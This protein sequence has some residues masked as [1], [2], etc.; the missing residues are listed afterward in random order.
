[1][2]E[3]VFS[4]EKIK[5]MILPWFLLI[6]GL[7]TMAYG[8]IFEV[9]LFPVYSYGVLEDYRLWEI[10]YVFI[11]NYA[12]RAWPTLLFAFM[13]GGF[14]I[15][16]IPRNKMQYYLSSGKYLPYF[17]AALLAPLM[18]VCSCAM[19]P[20]FGGLV[21]SGAGIG[22]AITFLLMAPAANVMALIT[23][24]DLI[25]LDMALARLVF[26]FI[27]AVIIGM[28]IGRTRTGKAVEKMFAGIKA[29]NVENTN[30]ISF[31]EKSWLSLQ[32]GMDLG[33]RVLP[34]L[35]AGLFVVSFIEAYLPS[36]L[37]ALYLTG[38]SGIGLAALLGVPLYTPT[39]V[40]VFFINSLL[41]MGMS[42]PAALAFLIGAPMASIPSMMGVA[43]IVGW[44]LVLRYAVLSIILAFFA[45]LI[46]MIV[47]NT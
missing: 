20:V 19:I 35:L 41:G 44:K 33:R 23:T 2:G 17:M 28:L 6:F 12:T 11:L 10:P 46:Y 38:V 21:I 42:Y 18:T 31:T 29:Q 30:R 25:S 36:E 13:L 22:P 39:L 40:E 27:G 14:L 8:K 47:V 16:F 4:T 34:Y 15:G 1:M 43:S 45:G 5:K 9:P 7:F 24:I 37:V 3:D 26:S 32:E